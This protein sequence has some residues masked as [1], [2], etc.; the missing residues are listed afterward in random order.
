MDILERIIENLSSDEVRRFKILSNRFKADE[1]K[2]LIILFDAIRN[3]G[4]KDIEDE[5][6][7]Q[8]YG[9]NTPKTKNSYYRLRNK[10]LS[11][12]EKS[13]LF[14]H[15]NYK[16]TLESHSHIQLAILLKE[17]GLYKEAFHYLKK[18]EKVA[19]KHDQFSVVEVVYDEMV[20]LAA[21]DINIDIDDIIL[22]RKENLEKMEIQRSTQEI[23]GMVAQ[24]ANRLNV[25]RGKKSDSLIEMLEQI[26]DKLEAYKGIYHSPT[27]RIAVARTVCAILLRRGV[28]EE[29]ETYIAKTFHEFEE[30][31]L[32]DRNTHS[33]RLLMRIWWINALRKLLR[34][35][36][37]SQQIILLLK[38]LKMYG[39]QNYNEYAIYYY[40]SKINNEKL[41]GNLKEAHTAL[42]EAMANKAVVQNDLN[43]LY[44]LISQ[45]DQYFNEE[46]FVQALESIKDIMSH[47]RFEDLDEEAKF[48]LSIFE[49]VVGHE[50]EKFTYTS[51]RYKSLRK[52]FRKLLSDSEYAKAYKF[53]TILMRINTAAIEG[54]SV[55]LRATYES[56]ISTYPKSEV[57]DN[58]IIMYEIYLDAKLNKMSYYNA[59][60]R[61]INKVAT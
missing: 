38:D 21:R 54:K 47:N 57:A 30:A 29:L 8:M 59:F 48:Y 46:N 6:V 5:V 37:E 19:Q 41:L 12:L 11:N 60:L 61:E 42:K 34:I 1:E 28:Y 56:F 20:Q 17:R 3:G 22:K 39:K 15:F 18:A 55:S 13:L 14:Y 45:A 26:K 16:N 58:Q 52:K 31:K 50:A 23:L 33:F 25:T 27:G 35:S 53:A 10:L 36:E 7:T 40:T 4:F 9:K 44:L 24:K 2:K 32:F 51:N 43:H 49:L